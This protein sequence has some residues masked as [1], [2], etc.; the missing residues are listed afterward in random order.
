M[1]C[2]FCG[3]AQGKIPTS[4][5]FE[6][7]QIMAFRDLNPQAPTHVLIIPKRHIS[8]IN[9]AVEADAQLFGAM[10]L[11][12]KTVAKME[13][14]DEKGYRLIFNVHSDGGQTVYHIH[15]HI[16]GGRAMT[17]PPG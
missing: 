11:A 8:T 13:K 12:A 9:D 7:E 16:L 5:V 17:W 10:V 3:I 1:T 4:V 15:L 2:V 14:I 6:N